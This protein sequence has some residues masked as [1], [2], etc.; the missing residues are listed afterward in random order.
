MVG[1]SGE[2]GPVRLLSIESGDGGSAA[3]DAAGATAGDARLCSD[4]GIADISWANGWACVPAAVPLAWATAAAWPPAPAGLVVCG[5]AVNGFTW[6][7]VAE[8]SA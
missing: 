1:G 8:E 7:A 4:C 5:G 6:E 3:V 2:N